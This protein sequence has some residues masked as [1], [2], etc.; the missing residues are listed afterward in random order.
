[1]AN[2]VVLI[3]YCKVYTKTEC[4]WIQVISLQVFIL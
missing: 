1:M 2:T 4:S 3:P